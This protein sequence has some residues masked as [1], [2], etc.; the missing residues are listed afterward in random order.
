MSDSDL[1]LNLSDAETSNKQSSTLPVK[2]RF[3]GE[4]SDD[5]K[6]AAEIN[7]AIAGDNTDGEEGESTAPK[8]KSKK[9]KRLEPDSDDSSIED[10][11]EEMTEA[12]K[13]FIVDDEEEEE[14]EEE[15]EGDDDLDAK[16]RRREQRRR[17]KRKRRRREEE[18]VLD[19]DDFDLIREN[20]YGRKRETRG[21]RLKKKSQD[22]SASAV[23]TKRTGTL[24]DMFK[25]EVEEEPGAAPSDRGVKSSVDRPAYSDDSDSNDGFV[26]NDDEYE[27]LADET[28]ADRKERMR[29]DKE[30]RKLERGKAKTFSGTYNISEE[31]WEDIED[32]FGDGSDYK[33]ALF[34]SDGS[35]PRERARRGDDDDDEH[36][37]ETPIK[38]TLKFSDVFEPEEIAKRHLT[39]ADEIIRLKDVPER[40]QLRPVEYPQL[41]E[42]DLEREILHI[43]SAIMQMAATAPPGSSIHSSP[44]LTATQESR[45]TAIKKILLFIHKDNYEIPFLIAHRKDHM[46]LIDE[47]GKF[48]GFVER[49]DLWRIHD[50]DVQFHSVEAKRRTVRN[51]ITDLRTSPELL[52]SGSV[53]NI[54]LNDMY[55]DEMLRT[56]KNIEDVNDVMVYLQLYY[57]EE[58]KKVEEAK[59][60]RVELKR[61]VRRSEYD[62]A[63]RLGIN[64]FVKL[65]NVDV[66]KFSESI[67][68]M[69]NLHTPEDLPQD[70]FDTAAAFVV[71]KSQ[72]SDIRRVIDAARM[73]LAHQ[74]AVDPNFRRF[75]RKVYE[76]DAVVTVNP[77]ERGKKEITPLHPYYKFKYLKEKPTYKFEKA[78]Y[79]L[80]HKAE[81]EGLVEVKVY[82]D[83]ETKLLEDIVKNITN[84]YTSEIA[85]RWNDERRRC[86]EKATKE[87]I[88]PAV[89][90]W[91]KEMM[92]AKATEWLIDDCRESLEKPYRRDRS[93][94][95][96]YDEE[97]VKTHARVMAITWGD[98]DPL[99]AAFAV[100]IDESG[101]VSSLTKLSS[102]HMR[103]QKL[104]DHD[105]ILSKLREFQIEVVVVGGT[106]ISTKTRLLPDLVEVI[107]R[108]N[109]DHD[110][111]SDRRRYRRSEFVVPEVTMIEDDVARLV[112]NSKRYAKEFPDYPP[113][114][115]YCVSLARRVQDTTFELATLY[116]SDEEIKLLQVHPHQNLLPEDKL[117]GAFERAFINVVNASGV[118]IND[119]VLHPHRANTLQFVS[120]LGPRKV[121]FLISRINKI[122]GRLPSRA[123]FVL[124]KML[125]RV[126]FMNCASFIRIHKKSFKQIRSV[127]LDVLDNTRIH[128]E[129][130]DIARKMAAGALDID[131][132]VETDDPSSHVAELME[133]H[134][135]RLDNLMLDDFADELYRT[136]QDLKRIALRD[137]KDEIIA[138]YHERRKKF[139]SAGWAEIFPM[140]TG[141]REESLLGMMMSCVVVKIFER[142]IRCKLTASGID[143]NLQN[144]LTPMQRK[145]QENEPFQAVV[146]KVDMK[147]FRVEIDAREDFVDSGK[148]LMDL[149]ASTRDRYFNLDKEEDDR[150]KKPVIP[151]TT[152]KPKRSRTINHP[153]WRN[154]TYQEAITELTGSNVRNGS[155]II[156]PSTKGNDHIC[157]TWKV[158]EDILE[159]NKENE[160]TLGKTLIIEK[161]KFDDLEEII[162]TYIEPM[163]LHFTEARKHPKYRSTSLDDTFHFLERE[164]QSKKRSSYAI[165]P[166]DKSHCMYLAYQHINKSPRHEYVYITP[167]GFKFRNIGYKR[168]DQMF[169]AFKRQEAQ[170]MKE[171]TAAAD[172]KARAAKQSQGSRP[173]QIPGGLSR[174]GAIPPGMS[175]LQQSAARPQ[176]PQSI[177][178]GGGMRNG[179]QPSIP[180]RPI[181]T[182]G[183]NGGQSGMAVRP[184]MP[185]GYGQP[186]QLPQAGGWTGMPAMRPM[187]P[188]TPN[189][190]PYG[191]P[192]MIS[193]TPMGFRP[194]PPP[195]S[196]GYYGR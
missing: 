172:A 141:E 152:A 61:A 148:W 8:R 40:F 25:D 181:M 86:A 93:R 45:Q 126:I 139:V 173:H 59:G 122:G 12:D 88:F 33:Y 189:A 195:Q 49:V 145:L 87:L 108:I 151:K 136:S 154:C 77:T 65:Y 9:L 51:L 163:A 14:E 11:D 129:D 112:M 157:I 30:R 74:I 101:R 1:D 115:R 113:W 166:C 27:G 142:F 54:L 155:L 124:E 118:D 31:V 175:S 147:E 44:I 42:E 107:K 36:R 70:P 41:S 22:S 56:A 134:P 2:N 53:Q 187:M 159:T 26:I 20:I 183:I 121:G 98:G 125:G 127:N 55:V 180:P 72:F 119:A 111:S 78:D 144:S 116:N 32:L 66:K 104:K 89:V 48:L 16:H 179:G 167:E 153:Y 117:K 99:T 158:D 4:D 196:G 79:L 28:E 174:S 123:H 58:I 190:L 15:V 106:T 94:D 24:D 102:M 161:K 171:A 18:E 100:C 63:K 135:E 91:F 169:D 80:I 57:S 149:A 138:P 182:A 164:V 67:T 35:K 34:A 178:S 194:Q 114:A 81:V 133:D 143:A 177:N 50:L 109:D 46:T 103:E 186:Q 95:D 105:V 162:A 137:I 7:D 128:P 96:D 23:G 60:R 39:D 84:D 191:A 120:G 188:Q 193:H 47:T 19:D 62:D 184:P 170:R 176:M 75:I 17:E 140:L 37:R 110:S 64:N 185:M 71:E 192:G 130:Y 69:R 90:K 83:E 5:D 73:M 82:V 156:R 29:A 43:E 3:L 168:L 21:G 92:A 150:E 38:K 131:E 76:T 13:G 132:V 68:F 85:E 160:W 97:D 146:T 10:S 165:I 52:S 6:I